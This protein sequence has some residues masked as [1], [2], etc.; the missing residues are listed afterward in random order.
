MQ[1]SSRL[2]NLKTAL[3]ALA[4][5]AAFSAA[6]PASAAPAE[7]ASVVIEIGRAHV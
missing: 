6:G 3:G 1:A 7:Q 4:V 2:F 5:A